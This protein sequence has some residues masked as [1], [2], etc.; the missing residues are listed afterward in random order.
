MEITQMNTLKRTMAVIISVAMTLFVV[1]CIC[2][3]RNFPYKLIGTTNYCILE[4]EWSMGESHLAR[5][6]QSGFDIVSGHDACGNDYI[7][8]VEPDGYI[9]WDERYIV[10]YCNDKPGGRNGKTGDTR[11]ILS[12]AQGELSRF[13]SADEFVE[14]ERKLN[15]DEARMKKTDARIPWSLHLFD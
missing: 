5:K 10:V 12:L 1:Y 9:L 15:I 11:F 6:R 3:G 13:L 8:I 7:C 14:A 4:S 2:F